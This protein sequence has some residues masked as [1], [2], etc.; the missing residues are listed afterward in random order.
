MDCVNES[1]PGVTSTL[2]SPQE[3]LKRFK[4]AKTKF[5]DLSVVGIAGPG[6]ALHDPYKT[7]ETFELIGQEDKDI[8]FC[9][10]TNGLMLP[11]YIHDLYALGLR[12]LTITINAMD[13]E[14]G[15]MIYDH[16]DYFG[17]RYEGVTGASLLLSNQLSGLSLAKSLGM[18]V[19]VNTVLLRGINDTHVTD[20]SK[21]ISNLGADM[22][23][24][25]QL[26]P[27]EGSKFHKLPKV[28]MEEIRELRWK[29]GAYLPQ[30]THCRQCRADAAG[31]LGEDRSLEFSCHNKATFKQETFTSDADT[32]KIAVVSKSAV[33]VDNH[34]G[35]A[36]RFY[37]YQSDGVSLKFLENRK[38]G[39]GFQRCG[40]S[41]NGVKKEK[42]KGYI[43]D[44]VNAV[45]D[46]DGIVAM[47]IGDSPREMLENKGI[48]C[49]MTYETVEKAV[50]DAALSLSLKTNSAELGG[51]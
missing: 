29:C 36:E 4:E 20:L 8:I 1:R 7:L 23:N 11:R 51:T 47:R 25:M 17:E 32:Y 6:E 30:M 33:L 14:I 13:P 35:Q 48:G 46:C 49:F 39:S 22:G 28:T 26:I 40:G 38:V 21:K 44:L 9:M 2:L 31:R 43:A 37:I 24:I 34:F 19:K 18:V 5:Q 41:C 16:I 50:L 45:S 10:S 42:P 12:H 3:A 27:V 15:S